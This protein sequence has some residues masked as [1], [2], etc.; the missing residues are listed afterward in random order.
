MYNLVTVFAILLGTRQA[1]DFEVCLVLGK[2]AFPLM[3]IKNLRI[4]TY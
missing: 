2:R 4:H 1:L 3:A